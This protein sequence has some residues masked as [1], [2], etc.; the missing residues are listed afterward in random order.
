MMRLLFEFYLS[1]DIDNINSLHILFAAF[2]AVWHERR[3]LLYG[4]N[5]QKRWLAVTDGQRK[6]EKTVLGSHGPFAAGQDVL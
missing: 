3:L 2:C 4:G 6:R 1:A 5:A